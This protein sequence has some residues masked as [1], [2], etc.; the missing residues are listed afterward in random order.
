M[1]YSLEGNIIKRGLYFTG[2]VCAMILKKIKINLL[3][4]IAIMLFLPSISNAKVKIHKSVD[5]G[6]DER[7]E[8][9]STATASKS[10]TTASRNGNICLGVLDNQTDYKIEYRG[11]GKGDVVEE[12]ITF[13]EPHKK[14]IWSQTCLDAYSTYS[15]R[16]FFAH[17]I[18]N[19]DKKFIVEIFYS[20]PSR[21][22]KFCVKFQNSSDSPWEKMAFYTH[23]GGEDSSRCY[24]SHDNNFGYP[25]Q[26]VWLPTAFLKIRLIEKRGIIFPIY[27]CMTNDDVKG[28]ISSDVP[29]T[30]CE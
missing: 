30:S 5:E 29:T 14:K 2:K 18:H 16:E 28:V 19:G 1:T 24:I 27:S 17:D 11:L 13:V 3:S 21:S 4:I 15:R 25:P 8:R 23:D 12:T 20:M 10:A 26:H 7:N 22:D 6:T 9:S